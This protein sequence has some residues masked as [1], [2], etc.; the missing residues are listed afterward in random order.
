MSDAPPFD[1]PHCSARYR[2]VKV[3]ADPA[4]DCELTCPVCSAPL[5]A[6]EGHFIFKYF[7]IAR[8]RR[9]ARAEPASS[10][11][12]FTSAPETAIVPELG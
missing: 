1:C 6:R 12:Y 2:V 4:N 9:N 8:P 11:I 10:R 7:L 3:E 5:K